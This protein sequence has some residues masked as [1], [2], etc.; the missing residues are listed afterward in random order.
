MIEKVT[1]E[2]IGSLFNPS[3]GKKETEGV[4]GRSFAELLK[5]AIEGVNEIQVEALKEMENLV[6]GRVDDIHKPIIAAEKASLALELLVQVRN[7]AVEAY[8]EIMRMQV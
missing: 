3:A 8:Q 5:N 6:L 1:T 4:E 2:G 7:K